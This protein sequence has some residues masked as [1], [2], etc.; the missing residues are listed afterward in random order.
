M[1]KI[2]SCKEYFDTLD[3]RFVNS[4]ASGVNAV[5][6]FSLSGDGGGDWAVVVNDGA[7]EVVPGA[8][9][10]PSATITADAAN[11]VKIANGDMNGL[12]AVMTGKMKVS[13]NIVLARKMQQMLPTGPMAD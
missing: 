13:G 9:D 8:H 12:R 4:A 3:K 7:M 1:G 2:S 6:Q 10:S 11:Y 5:Y